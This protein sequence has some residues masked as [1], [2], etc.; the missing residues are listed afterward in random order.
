MPDDQPLIVLPTHPLAEFRA[1]R[2]TVARA[3]RALGCGPEE[4]WARLRA[5]IENDDGDEQIVGTG[6]QPLASP[7]DADA[8]TLAPDVPDPVLT[9]PLPRSG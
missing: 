4:L 8:G 1:G 6:A 9:P 2:L 5:P 3:C 7:H